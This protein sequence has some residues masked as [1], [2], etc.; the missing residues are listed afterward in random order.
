MHTFMQCLV[1]FA[2]T[3]NVHRKRVAGT[4]SVLLGQNV[5]AFTSL[6]PGEHAGL[7]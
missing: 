5:F 2:V 6:Q 4:K 1:L 3:I 7:I